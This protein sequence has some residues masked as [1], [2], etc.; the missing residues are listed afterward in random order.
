LGRATRARRAEKR[1]A[2]KARLSEP[3][4]TYYTICCEAG[5]YVMAAFRAADP[6]TPSA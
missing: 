2:R 6:T 5:D 3:G 1:A 4:K